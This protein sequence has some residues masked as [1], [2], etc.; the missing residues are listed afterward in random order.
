MINFIKFNRDIYISMLLKKASD[1]QCPPGAAF[2]ATPT[3]HIDG[4]FSFSDWHLICRIVVK[5]AAINKKDL[6]TW[7]IEWPKFGRLSEW[8]T[9]FKPV[10]SWPVAYHTPKPML[11]VSPI[12]QWLNN[13]PKF[14]M[15][16]CF[17]PNI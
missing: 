8:P 12:G 3:I 16:F 4:I 13:N 7:I 1:S 11:S 15:V 6:K 5:W 2:A 10:A 17:I 9:F 14:A